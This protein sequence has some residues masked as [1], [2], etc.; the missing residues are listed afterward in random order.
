[1]TNCQMQYIGTKQIKRWKYI[2]AEAKTS[3]TKDVVLLKVTLSLRL[4]LPPK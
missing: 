1:M 3:V 2:P 4:I